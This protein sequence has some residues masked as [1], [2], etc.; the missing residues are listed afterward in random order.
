MK[1][2]LSVLLV[3][4]MV[5]AFLPTELFAFA[6][7]SEYSEYTLTYDF[8]KSDIPGTELTKVLDAKYEHTMGFW[9]FHSKDPNFTR[10]FRPQSYGLQIATLANQWAALT[11][12]VPVA[13]KY[14]A[15]YTHYASTS[16]K[17]GT[18]YLI[19]DTSAN[20]EE[21]IANGDAIILWDG[22]YLASENGIVTEAE[23]V[24]VNLEAKEYVVVF[25]AASGGNNQWPTSI[26]F[27]GGD[28][29][30][31]T[32]VLTDKT[33]FEIAKGASDTV[34]VTKVYMSD[35]SELTSGY[36]VSYS[37]KDNGIATVDNSG[38]ITG[39][40]S[41]K[42]EIAATVTYDGA[43][44]T[45]LM[46]V[47]V[48]IPSV[49][50]VDVSS[51]STKLFTTEEAVLSTK[52]N[53][54][55]GL[56]I[57]DIDNSEVVYNIVE[58][59]A[60]VT[61]GV[62]TSD[63]Q[64]TVKITATISYEGDSYT[65][66]P[67]EI[68]FEKDNTVY[69]EYTL[70]YDFREYTVKSGDRLETVGYAE[71]YGFWSYHSVKP[72]L[73]I[74]TF[75]TAGYGMQIGTSKNQWAAFSIKVPVAGTYKTSLLHNVGTSGGLGR[76]YIFK[77]GM[78]ASEIESEI[79]GDAVALGD[80][81]F[82]A[83]SSATITTELGKCNFDAP[84]EYIIVFATDK[85]SGK[86]MYPGCL[87]FSGGEEKA[88][89]AILPKSENIVTEIGKT[90]QI[91]LYSAYLSDYTK[92]SEEDFT[93]SYES[94]DNN[95]VA[96]SNTG[97]IT[98]ISE[99]KAVVTVSATKAVATAQ[100]KVN[101][102][103]LPEGSSG[104][105]AVY[106]LTSGTEAFENTTYDNT[107]NF[108][109]YVGKS[110]NVVTGD[111]FITANGSYVA[112]GI[113]VPVE[114]KY[115]FNLSYGTSS[116]GGEGSVHILPGNTSD[117]A[118]A[119]NGETK[120]GSVNYNSDT[121]GLKEETI[122][123]FT[124]KNKGEYIVVFSADN[125]KQFPGKIELVGG[126]KTALMYVD[127][128]LKGNV[129]SATKGVLSD[130]SATDLYSAD[131]RYDVEDY[132]VASINEDNGRLLPDINGGETVAY[133]TATLD[134][135]TVTGKV[136]VAFSASEDTTSGA[137]VIYTLNEASESWAETHR[138]SATT[139]N[140]KDITYADTDGLWQW[141]S[142]SKTGDSASAYATPGDSKSS[143]LRLRLYPNEWIAL[144]IKVPATG[145]YWVTTTG[146]KNTG[147]QGKAD[148]YFVPVSD[149]NAEISGSLTEDAFAAMVDYN[150]ASLSG[151]TQITEN[152]GSVELSQGEY[153]MVFKAYEGSTEWA[154]YGPR[155]VSLNGENALCSL[156]FRLDKQELEVGENATSDVAARLLDGTLLGDSEVVL[157]YTSENENVA[158]FDDGIITGT[159]I[160]ET[161]VSVTAILNGKVIT[162]TLPVTV[163][164]S[165][166]VSKIEIEAPS[167]EYIRNPA[168]LKTYVVYSSGNRLK[169]DNSDVIYSIVNGNAK[170][171]EGY[172][173]AENAGNVEVTAQ[174]TYNEIGY[175]SESVQINFIEGTYKTGSTFYTP[176]RIAAAREN[177]QKYDWAKKDK[178]NIVKNADTYLSR[179]ETIYNLIFGEGLPRAYQTGAK[180]DPD[181]ALCRY[182]GVNIAAKY[183]AGNGGGAFNINI[184][185]NPWKIQCPDCKRLFP[186]NDFALLYERGLDEHG[187]YDRDRALAANA[188]AV[189]R[190][191]KDALVNELYPELCDPANPLYNKDPRTGDPVDGK[192]WGV[193]DGY[194]YVTGRTYSNGVEERHN[195]IA[196]Y[197]DGFY[198]NVRYATNYLSVAYV[199]TGD[200][201][202][203]RAGALL[204]DRVADVYPSFHL[205]QWDQNVYPNRSGG[206][207]YGKIVGSISD[208]NYLS[209]VGFLEVCDSFFPILSD[210]QIIRSLSE[211]SSRFN[212]DNPKTTPEL[213]W[214]NWEEGIV[215][216]VFKAVQCLE[217]NGNFGMDQQVI[218]TAAL[219]LDRQPESRQMI[220]WIFRTGEKN[221]KLGTY[222]GG[223]FVKEFIDVIDRDGMGNEGA[224]NYNLGW[225]EAIYQT[226]DI[227]ARMYPDDPQYNL[228]ENPK[229]AKMFTSGI[230]L[231]ITENHTAQ[232]GD[233]GLPAGIEFEDSD[234]ALKAGFKQLKD[235]IF[236]NQLAEYL[237][238][239]N[240]RT[241]ES[242]HYG[243][244]EKDPEKIQKEI[245]E[246]VDDDIS[247]GSDMMTGFGFAILRDGA[248]NG[249]KTTATHT[250]SQRDFW[251]YFGGTTTSHGHLDALNLGV[252]AY[253]LNMAPDLGYPE[254]TGTDPN[255]G[256]WMR[257]T[258]SH[259]TVVVNEKAQTARLVAGTP[260]HFDDSDE[261]KVM[262]IDVSE[263]YA[264]TDIYRRTVVMVNAG[265]DVSY[266]VDFFRVKGGD[267]HIYSFHA[268]SDEIY[269]TNGLG[270][271][272]YQTDDGTVSG[273]YV[274]TY[275]GRDVEY[276]S[277]PSYGY[278]SG[279]VYPAGYTWMKN[280][281]RASDVENFFVDFKIKDF[282]KVLKDGN[283]LH[284]RLTM[285][286]DKALDEVALTSGHVP[287]KP[288][289]AVLPKTLEYVLARRKGKNLD[290]LYTAIYEPYRNNRYLAD[291]SVVNVL[292]KDGAEGAN[293]TAKALKVTRTDGR[294][295]YIVYVTN[296][297]VLYTV[298]DGDISFDFR[299]FV[300]VYSVNKNGENIYSYINDGDIIGER[301]GIL[302]E[303]TGKVVGFSEE[304]TFENYITVEFNENVAD[305]LLCGKFVYI[306]N[307]GEQNA[308]YRIEDATTENGKTRLSIGGISL[309][310]A[311]RNDE[312]ISEGFVY[313]VTK[314]QRVSVPLSDTENFAPVF[315]SISDTF[316][317]SVGSLI[318]IDVNAESP[319]GEKV[320]YIGTTVPRGAAVDENTGNVTWKPT[321]AQLG[322]NYF[323]I[324][325]Q[326]ESGRERTLE[327]IVS[328]YGSTGGA[329]GG[330][331]G[332]TTTTP[333]EPETPKKP[334]EETPEVPVVPET[335]TRFVDL[336]AHPWAVEAINALAEEGIIKGTSENTFSPGNNITRA[337]FAILLVRAFGLSSDNAENFADVSESD[338]FA[339][340]LAVARNTGI[341]NGIGDNKYAPRNTITRQDMMVIVYRALKGF[342]NETRND[343]HVVPYGDFE[344]V[345]DYAKKAVSALVGAGLVNGKNG[346]IAPLD[347]TTR[348][349]VAVL[350]QRVLDYIKK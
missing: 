7:D 87:T 101:I 303:A 80:V 174:V 29:K 67:F 95:V 204:I 201:K 208:C 267:D 25:K 209:G 191:E 289:N 346:R 187:Y 16:G 11:I 253:G 155:I 157:L 31:V 311:M 26:T 343:T 93:L 219:V 258:I 207:G 328:V 308:V 310:R 218:S 270:E 108:W 196:F 302:S 57:K 2:L 298:T 322:R 9:K 51:T 107:F 64:G 137:S 149:S 153:L 224:T 291:M 297:S 285:L 239:R 23:T 277:D 114:G 89:A 72:G 6:Y 198:S 98:G 292:V 117:I 62:V 268:L 43:A 313:N 264:E 178:E 296:N 118:T 33:S 317:T 79:S 104:Y 280:V 78:T 88:I 34:S 190:G 259:N 176:E 327:F 261:V 247:L 128:E 237:Y 103:V 275:A 307:D 334:E 49:T 100:T 281:R 73:T 126:E 112:I 71:T 1:R 156:N 336:G 276:G 142:E 105:T 40:A 111:N 39:V 152:I 263:A 145:R 32:S 42:T 150:D 161:K 290:T 159:G 167:E 82:N 230:P 102:T 231:M 286:N 321:S 171:E 203:G 332:A 133:A 283:G 5:V 121:E 248:K 170:I 109:R 250:D 37:S 17:A 251:I 252:E 337:D 235:T 81:N 68:V 130:G 65:S 56:I 175:T 241:V 234:E 330:G 255:R 216:E 22:T 341:V 54:N 134:G 166:G 30:A 168:L 188:E 273:N 242:L 151:L 41:G 205:E 305:E 146:A 139:I 113:N 131:I 243:I 215:K 236:G 141:H 195:Y 123:S 52:L 217:L 282:R 46:P 210:P 8:R 125:G 320:T 244:Y 211:S 232:I 177:I 340:E 301:S 279:F 326:D 227:L 63:T 284:L 13:G 318:N 212:L 183:G 74:N 288:K 350:I 335:T 162:K 197:C 348:A 225:P 256:Q 315:D 94:S 194:G 59:S 163:S 299:G 202:Y 184:Y 61:N 77:S 293:D 189:A 228:Y 182:C 213:I 21:T 86:N 136:D 278:T 172:I 325:A 140:M 4:C 287:Q 119:I 192:K 349:E 69:S 226:A 116:D 3:F 58:G 223:S 19:S 122:D 165:S 83:A 14:K 50:S 272:A 47:T 179:A 347:S 106:D 75:R 245:L 28:K 91:S 294:T 143:R 124:F 160:G 309:I 260:L 92:A 90:S 304:L 257:Q 300:G 135:I 15:Q 316:T 295:D 38:K 120:L 35:Y 306:E 129:V 84:G 342:L 324:T 60:T 233:S 96:V 323:V 132:S 76:V 319:F 249:D 169:L 246:R 254:K 240:G 20:I 269:E 66:E 338:Y 333:N 110:G 147:G 274:G 314:G 206:D 173:S 266:G 271:I 27:I 200:I 331:G 222:T 53:L 238:M 55:N 10:N 97:E 186:S 70:N 158:V 44:A 220:D 127:A 154:Y 24:D 148:I 265:S 345:A 185:N 344:S 221:N 18:V 214:K 144:K 193:D 329:G 36:T 45:T 180:D 12:N 138:P 229:F 115:K 48:F 199:Y 85:T 164:D 339:K 312:D 99:G 181:Y 262:D